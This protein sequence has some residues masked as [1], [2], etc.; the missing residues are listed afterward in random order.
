M[1]LPATSS[2]G[3]GSREL[4]FL[5]GTP[6]T[7]SGQCAVSDQ[8]GDQILDF[9]GREEVGRIGTRYKVRSFETCGKTPY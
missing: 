5:A 9:C 7:V 4:N 8:I 2:D 3:G 6:G 1:L